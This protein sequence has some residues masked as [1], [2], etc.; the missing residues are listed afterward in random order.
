MLV[1]CIKLTKKADISKYKYF[2]YDIGFDGKGPFSYPSCGLG[3][4]VI[5]FWVDM[6]SSVDVY[7]K[8]KRYFNSSSRSY[9]RVK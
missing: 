1:W 9:T 2:R 4:N 3:N 8:K 7:N 6:S 5:V